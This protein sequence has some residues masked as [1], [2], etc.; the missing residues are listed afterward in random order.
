MYVMENITL[1]PGIARWGRKEEMKM[2]IKRFFRK[3]DEWTDKHETANMVLS[4]IFG[5]IGVIV[6]GLIAFAFIYC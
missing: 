2:K 3:L 6:W 5:I 4:V 1:R